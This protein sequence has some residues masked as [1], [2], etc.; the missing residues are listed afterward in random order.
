MLYERENAI[1]KVFDDKGEL[2]SYHQDISDKKGIKYTPHT[3]SIYD[4][5]L[6]GSCWTGEVIV[7]NLEKKELVHNF[8]G[9][10]SKKIQMYDSHIYL[11]NT[12]NPSDIQSYTLNGSKTKLYTF[13]KHVCCFTLIDN[14]YVGH[15]EEIACY[16]LDGKLKYRQNLA[17]LNDWQS[18]CIAVYGE[19]IYLSYTKGIQ[20]YDLNGMLIKINIY[21]PTNKGANQA[22][23]NSF[24][25]LD[26]HLYITEFDD[27]LIFK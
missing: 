16:S 9:I 12:D 11:L 4:G 8:K 17:E 6:Y 25:L 5:L 3:F 10:N 21:K 22:F 19:F 26:G 14:I 2:V 23:L 13:D 20:Q 15:H 24:T 7:Y 1:I 18:R 27:V